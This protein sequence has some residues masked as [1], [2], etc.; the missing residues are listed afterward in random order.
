MTR[1]RSFILFALVLL[2]LYAVIT[3]PTQSAEVMR[4]AITGLGN[5][6][7]Q[8]WSFFGTLFHG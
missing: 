3:N 7:Q 4:N 6:L 2:V 8:I 1:A 5:A